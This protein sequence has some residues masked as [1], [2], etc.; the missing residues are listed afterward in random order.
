MPDVGLLVRALQWLEPWLRSHLPLKELG[1]TEIGEKFTRFVLFKTRRLSVYLHKLDAPVRPPECHDH[2]WHFWVL[3]L[4]H[5]YYEEM[6]GRVV[7][8]R[9]GEVFYRP[10]V[11]LHNTITVPGRPNWSVIVV[12][13]RRRN[14]AKA[15]CPA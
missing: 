1:W 2:P 8:R 14:W 7:W 4:G 15:A 11:S 13:G 9:P 3:V 6:R 10:A 12:S 5:G